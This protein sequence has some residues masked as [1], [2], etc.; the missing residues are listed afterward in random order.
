MHF[1][2]GRASSIFGFNALITPDGTKVV[3]ATVAE[4]RRPLRSEL[5]FTE[6]SAAT[7]RV[8]RVLDRWRFSAYPG[9]TQ[10]VLWTSP[11][12]SKLIVVAHKPGA[13]TVSHGTANYPI[14]IGVLT[15]NKFT[16][17]PGA[18]PADSPNGWPVF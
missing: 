11:S 2:H 14:V 1:V 8:V 4:T 9:Q 18:P 3:L 13:S 16:P 6:F 15:G 12:G 7:G 17:L 10:D 5:A